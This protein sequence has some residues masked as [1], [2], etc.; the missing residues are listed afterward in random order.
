M[1]PG[2]TKNFRFNTTYSADWS[3]VDKQGDPIA[4]DD[5]TSATFLLKKKVSDAD[6]DAIITKTTDDG[7]SKASGV[8]T[9]TL[10]PEDTEDLE[11]TYV[12]TLRLFLASGSVQDVYDIE[13]PDDPLITLIIKRGAVRATS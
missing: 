12:G 9:A 3:V 7:I 1:S 13:Y 10:D 2:E 4:A 11:G 8:V 5:I 6:A